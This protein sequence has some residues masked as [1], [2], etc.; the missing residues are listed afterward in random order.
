[1]KKITFIRHAKVDM[2]SSTPITSG[3]L[4]NWEDAYNSAPIIQDIPHDE[5]LHKTFIEAD[6]ILSSTLRRTKDSVALLGYCVDD[7]HALF[8]EAK[9]PVLSGN[10]MRLKP[11]SWMV[12]FRLLSLI[13]FGRWAVTLKETRCQAKEASKVLM[14]LSKEHDHIILVGHGVMNWLIRKELLVLEW[15]GKDKDAHGNWGLTVLFKHES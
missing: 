14:E 8:D 6:Y 5:T 10:F 1:M 2:D 3:M 7:S 13:G 12:V 4:K 11:T 15:Q 9:I